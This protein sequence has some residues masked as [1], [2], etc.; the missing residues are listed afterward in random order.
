MFVWVAFVDAYVSL[1]VCVCMCVHVLAL[2]VQGYRYLS[3]V[4]VEQSCEMSLAHYS[5]VA[6]SGEEELTTRRLFS[7]VVSLT[8]NT[9][10]STVASELPLITVAPVGKPRVFEEDSQVSVSAVGLL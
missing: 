6:K 3:G 2:H 8:R 5:R 9:Q 1:P 7:S 4:N 10:C